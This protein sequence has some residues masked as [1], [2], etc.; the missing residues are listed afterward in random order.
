MCFAVVLYWMMNFYYQFFLFIQFYHTFCWLPSLSVRV[1]FKYPYPT[2]PPCFNSSFVQTW[3]PPLSCSNSVV[4][5]IISY[6]KLPFPICQSG[7][8]ISLKPHD[9]SLNLHLKAPYWLTCVSVFMTGCLYILNF[10]KLHICPITCCFCVLWHWWR[11][12][13]TNITPT[14]NFVLPPK[15]KKMNHNL[16]IKFLSDSKFLTQSWILNLQTNAVKFDS[17]DIV[18][19]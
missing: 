5:F 3:A 4:V 11:P 7:T 13:A 16:Y 12:Q 18:L 9:C 1:F 10:L 17:N 15:K 8:I 14:I 19:M 6:W 2:G